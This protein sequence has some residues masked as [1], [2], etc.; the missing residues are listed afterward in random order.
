MLEAGAETL[1]LF[2]S[3]LLLL[4]APGAAERPLGRR[5][6]A[7]SPEANNPTFLGLAVDDPTALAPEGT[8]EAD[9]AP[10]EDG[11][12]ALVPA[13]VDPT[14]LAPEE[15]AEAALTP[16]DDEP[17]ALVPADVDP[18][19]L[20]PADDVPTAVT[21]E[22]SVHRR[23]GFGGGIAAPSLKRR[24]PGNVFLKW[25]IGGAGNVTRLFGSTTLGITRGSTSLLLGSIPSVSK[26]TT[27]P[28][29][30]AAERV[31]RR[32]AFFS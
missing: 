24:L 17:T 16:E 4:L 20:T 19:A 30:V 2:L 5:L 15:T 28:L 3:R 29:N 9:L 8:E 10:E 12:T 14:A 23:L 25:S 22:S 6:G 31:W 21:D 11:P 13:D 27:L 7:K 1:G 26:L 32:M 18:T